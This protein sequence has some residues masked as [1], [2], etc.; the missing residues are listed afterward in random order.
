MIKLRGFLETSFL[1]W[2]GKVSCVVFVPN[3]NYNCPFCSNWL[4]VHEPDSLPEVPLERIAAFIKERADFLDGVVVT[5]GEP[6]VHPD[7]PALLK[8][9]K[10]LGVLVKLDTNGTNPSMLA[11]LIEQKLVDYFAMD[12]K[13]P[14]NDKY[15]AAAGAKVDLDNIRTSIKLIMDSGVDYEFR[16]TVIPNLLGLPEIAE[17]A[18]TIAGAKKYAL[19]QFVPAHSLI[20]EMQKLDP[21]PAETLQEMAKIARQSV[22]N[23]IVRGV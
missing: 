21:H 8:R 11:K 22:P 12:I 7:L 10:E 4:L 19:Q 17:I 15:A 5:G 6:T 3:C 23:T 2:D 13:A 16:T 1:D 20:K 18:R 9:F 14:L